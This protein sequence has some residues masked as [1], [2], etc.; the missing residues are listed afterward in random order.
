MM[1]AYSQPLFPVG[2]I[3]IPHFPQTPKCGKKIAESTGNKGDNALILCRELKC[4]CPHI[5]TQTSLC[6][7]EPEAACPC[8]AWT[9]AQR[10][11][12]AHY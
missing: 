9:G 11:N 10:H 4:C 8:L 12:G 6:F 7:L 3:Q 2:Q 5:E 1:V